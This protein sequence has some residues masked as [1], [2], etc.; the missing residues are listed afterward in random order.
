MR[1][2]LSIVDSYFFSNQTCIQNRVS[3][4]HQLNQLMLRKMAP[5]AKIKK[6]V[7]S[8]VCEVGATNT[9][10]PF[11]SISFKIILRT[12]EASSR[13][14]WSCHP[15]STHV[16]TGHQRLASW[17]PFAGDWLRWGGKEGVGR[18]GVFCA[19]LFLRL[20]ESQ[21]LEWFIK[22]QLG[23]AAEVAVLKEKK[24]PKT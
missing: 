7:C 8:R 22:V 3:F 21:Q 9:N 11:S 1:R 23:T 19:P 6:V 20:L 13:L 16:L 12:K 14:A 15:W 2:C 24:K 5:D 10:A 4:S 17:S 18:K